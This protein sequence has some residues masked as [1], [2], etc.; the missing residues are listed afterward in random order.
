[1]P[2][3]SFVQRNL[4]KG[5]TPRCWVRLRFAAADGSLYEREL[6][7]DTGS[8]CAVIMGQA[9][10][11]LLLRAVAAGVNSNF[12]HLTGG[13]LELAMPELGLTN[14]VLGYG[15]DQVFQAVQSGESSFAGLVGLPVLRM[16]EYGGDCD[17]FW[18]GKPGR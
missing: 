6:L 9:D 12:G 13:W 15:S 11:A 2:P 17:A 16:V 3:T 7:A 10:L 4:Y 8:P 5:T 1:M 14:Q 18:L